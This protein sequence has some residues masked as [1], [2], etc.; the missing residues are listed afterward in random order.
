M[1]TSPDA[2]AARGDE[3]EL[4]RAYNDELVRTV[5]RAVVTPNMQTVEDACAFAWAAFLEHQ[6]DRERN[7]QG[8]MFPV[9]QRQ[10]WFLEGQRLEHTGLRTTGPPA[11][12]TH[13]APTPVDPMETWT[14]IDDALS[15]GRELPPRLQRIA[16]LRALGFN[17]PEI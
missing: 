7:W 8:W 4:F 12:H 9:A 14:D 10:A 13:E 1:A 11:P 3:A 6:P 2:P 5:A 16:I 17:Y 15:I